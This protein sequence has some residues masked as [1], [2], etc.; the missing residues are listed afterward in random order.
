MKFFVCL[1]LLS[2]VS[3]SGCASHDYADGST[4]DVSVDISSMHRCSRI[5]PEIEI[6]DA[7]RTAVSFDVTLEDMSDAKR[8][9]GGGTW[10]AHNAEHTSDEDIIIPE[11]ALTRFY[12]GPCPPAGT[13]RMYQY[14][15]KALDANNNVLAVRKYTFEQE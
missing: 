5:S 6:A 11:G 15:V 13:E 3:L 1:F 7:P 9:H 2:A 8:M 14:I 12:T 4:M 10:Q